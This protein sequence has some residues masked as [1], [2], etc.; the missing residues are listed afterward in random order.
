[1]SARDAV[2]IGQPTGRSASTAQLAR[3][4]GVCYLLVIAGGLFAQGVVRGSLIVP[5]DAAATAQA[6]A[7]NE[8][9]WRWGLAIHLLYLIPATLVNVILYGL[10]K[11]VHATLARLGLVFSMVGVTVEAAAL[12]ALAGPLAIIEE[13]TALTGLGVEQLHALAYLAV[14]LFS[15]GFGFS[16]VFFA[17]FC[18]LAG[19][20]ILRSRLVPPVIGAMMIAAGV[21]Y[22]TNSLVA[23]LSPSL[24]TMLFPWVLL[25]SLL[26]ELALALWL[27][28]KGV[29]SKEP[30]LT[31]AAA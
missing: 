20:L 18:A 29:A 7:A 2:V 11:H 1:M 16:L 5:G 27:V 17:C 25:P 12:L 22:A 15:T 19:V 4:A 3:I 9:L 6:I 14:R 26:A 13:G 28:F 21:C 24:A 8:S 31:L 30:E 10:F 23:L